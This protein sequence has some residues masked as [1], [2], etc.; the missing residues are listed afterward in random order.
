VGA[1]DAAHRPTG[2]RSSWFH[3]QFRQFPELLTHFSA[4]LADGEGERREVRAAH[5]RSRARRSSESESGSERHR[6]DTNYHGPCAVSWAEGL[7][8]RTIRHDTAGTARHDLVSCRHGTAL[9]R[10]VPARHSGQLYLLEV[11]VL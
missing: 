3:F 2:G 6:H 1:W 8:H 7:A 10:V 5:P 4:L 9:P 11:L